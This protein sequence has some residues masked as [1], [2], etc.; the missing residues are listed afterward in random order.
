MNNSSDSINF[1]QS[2]IHSKLSTITYKALSTSSPQ[3]LASLIHYHEPVVSFRFSDHHLITFHH[4]I[5][6]SFLPLIYYRHLES[7]VS[8]NPL[9]SNHEY[10]H[11]QLK[12]T[13][14]P[15][16]SHLGLLSLPPCIRFIIDNCMYI[17]ICLQLHL[18]HRSLVL[19]LVI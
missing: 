17:N 10:L 15:L 16:P 6:H 2:R 5:L 19:Y 13:L 18:H 3:N 8:Q 1:I 11:T 9:F 7:I 14:L 12:D 4:S